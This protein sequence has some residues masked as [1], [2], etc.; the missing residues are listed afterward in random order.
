MF[1]KRREDSVEA[2]D[3]F[4][5]VVFLAGGDACVHRKDMLQRHSI[6]SG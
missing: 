2:I 6:A 4:G 5:N 1:F 3:D